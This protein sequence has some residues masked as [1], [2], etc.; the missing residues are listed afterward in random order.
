MVAGKKGKAGGPGKKG[1]KFVEDKVCLTRSR[2]ITLYLAVLMC[3]AFLQSA[4]L[5]LID[6]LPRVQKESADELVASEALSAK[7]KSKSSA[8]EDE[9]MDVVS[10]GIDSADT[11]REG[12][13]KDQSSKLQDES[14]KTSKNRQRTKAKNRALVRIGWGCWLPH[15]ACLT[16]SPSLI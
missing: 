12:K 11:S 10:S 13:G 4:L 7:G 3:R 16:D 2:I 5:S 9:Q 14:K 6:S 1:K 8:D 15:N